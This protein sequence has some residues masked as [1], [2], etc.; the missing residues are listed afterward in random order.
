MRYFL[1]FSWLLAACASQRPVTHSPGVP[2]DTVIAVGTI[3]QLDLNGSSLTDVSFTNA[4]VAELASFP[5]KEK[6]GVKM[7]T[8]GFAMVHIK[9]RNG[10]PDREKA[11]HVVSFQAATEFSQVSELLRGI[12][13]IRVEVFSDVVRIAGEL[14]HPETVVRDYDRIYQAETLFTCL[15][16]VTIADSLYEAAAV[17]M[18]R[19][20]EKL[21]G[22][23]KVKVRVL[24]GTFLLE[25][26]AASAAV[27]ERAEI[28]TTTLLPPMKGSEAIRANALALGA[29]KFS[30]RNMIQVNERAPSSACPKN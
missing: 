28:I 2:A 14:I 5:T 6:F 26:E 17:Q 22:A 7:L 3:D 12:Q 13:G 11:Y 18:Q 30:I 10:A 25:G 29:K 1:L 16:T 21:D 9:G 27:R 8:S 15:N 4:R 19:E 24:N 20:I 23:S